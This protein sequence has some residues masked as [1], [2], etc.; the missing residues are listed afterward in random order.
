LTESK[1]VS[2][3]ASFDNA[4]AVRAGNG[5]GIDTRKS[6]AVNT[7]TSE[8]CRAVLAVEA[9]SATLDLELDIDTLSEQT[10]LLAGCQDFPDDD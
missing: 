1:S 4:F 10:R 8:L 5:K 9:S 2:G 3:R 6:E 7:W